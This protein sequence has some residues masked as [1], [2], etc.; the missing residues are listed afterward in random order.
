MVR[1]RKDFQKRSVEK[2]FSLLEAFH[3][4]MDRVYDQVIILGDVVDYGPNP[5]EVLEFSMNLK[6]KLV[7]MGNHD[8]L[9]LKNKGDIWSH[10][11]YQQLTPSHLKI[12][13]SFKSSPVMFPNQLTFVHASTVNNCKYMITSLDFKEAFTRL[14]TWISFLGT[15]T[16]K[17]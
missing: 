14:H 11:T 16:Y 17:Q 8:Y 10:W 1:I 12:I 15:H 6:P 5:R 2:L 7:L 13:A 4:G 3:K 9:V